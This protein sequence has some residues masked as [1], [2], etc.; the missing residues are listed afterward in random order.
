MFKR[1]LTW[2]LVF[3]LMLISVVPHVEGAFV[4]SSL[5]TNESGARDADMGRIQSVLESKVVK[6]RLQ[7]LG[8]NAEEAA[9]KL[10]LLSDQQLHNYAQQLDSLRTGGDALGGIIGVLVIILLIILILQ[11]TGHKVIVK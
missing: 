10:S 4:P 1:T 5:I 7:D 2:Y 11:L 6:Q 8:Y 9:G 3:A